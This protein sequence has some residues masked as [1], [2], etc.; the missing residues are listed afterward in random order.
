MGHARRIG[1][2]FGILIG[3][4]S[5]FASCPAQEA[6]GPIKDPAPPEVHA[7]GDARPVSRATPGLE[8][9]RSPKPLA[10]GAV[11]EDW[12][13]FLGPRHDATSKESP[14]DK[15]FGEEGPSLVWDLKTGDGYASP[16][17]AGD[18]LVLFHRLGDEEIVDRLD[19][20]TG[21]RYWR[22]S[23][24]TEY[25]DDF[26]YSGGPK[27]SP[28]LEGDLCWTYGIE[29]VLTALHLP[30]GTV[31]WQRNLSK[32]F[33]IPKGFF[34]V[35]APPLL[36]GDELI[37]NIGVPGGPCVAGFDK[38]TGR[39][40]WGAGSSYLASYASPS[41]ATLGGREKIV[42]F[43]GGKLRPPK[44]GLMIIDRESHTIDLEYP[45]RSRTYYSVNASTPIVHDGSIFISESYGLGGTRL[46]IDDEVA[47]EPAWTNERFDMHWHT[48]LL[49]AGH[50]Y[51]FAGQ[52]ERACELV[53]VDW[54]T[55]EERWRESITW[56]EE[57]EGNAGPR[58]VTRGV[59]R[60]SLLQVDGA[61]LCLGEWGDL[62]WLKLSPKGLEV[63]ARTK[64]F[65][66]DQTWS[67]PVI[68]RGLLYICQNT[69]ARVTRS[70]PRLYCYDMRSR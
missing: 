67:L 30:S 8:R 7:P 49:R 69:P 27:C 44:G 53:C 38:K 68:S 51:G 42:V 54:K 47:A 24:P 63:L 45:W 48:P 3:M 40:L 17:I 1:I 22:Q 31:L 57:I 2:G 36:W 43:A 11:T 9:H 33:E 62:L 18:S 55:G 20:E 5:T 61:T 34:G 12:P 28:I 52:K 14:I 70:A 66:A 26:G 35:G 25:I 15:T 13:R 64:L 6:K 10:D 16:S 21:E 50:L 4:V 29:G 58:R 46:V 37:I 59:Y 39:L 65:D 41:P 19:P 56:D 23:Y 60:G 32:D